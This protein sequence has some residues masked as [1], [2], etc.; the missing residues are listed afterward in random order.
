MVS[1]M[2]ITAARIFACGG[3]LIAGATTRAPIGPTCRYLS[4]PALTQL[5]LQIRA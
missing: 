5:V 3:M 1:V 4:R 2:Y